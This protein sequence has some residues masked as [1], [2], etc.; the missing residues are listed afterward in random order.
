[1]VGRCE[2]HVAARD[3]HGHD[4]GRALEIAFAEIFDADDLRAVALEIEAGEDLFLEAFDVD[5]EQGDPLLRRQMLGENVV[6]CPN[7]YVRGGDQRVVG[8]FDQPA[9]PISVEGIS[10]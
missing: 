10:A 6:E 2:H 7:R 5:R 8:V 9:S 3:Q 4:S 1:M